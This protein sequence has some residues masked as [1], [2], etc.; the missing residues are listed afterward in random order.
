MTD[1]FESISKDE[2]LIDI[3]A[4]ERPSND[5][6]Y[7]KKV[8]NE[9]NEN[10][11]SK[12]QP[13]EEKSES[14]KNSHLNE[15][16]LESESKSREEIRDIEI[17]IDNRENKDENHDIEIQIDN[18]KKQEEMLDIGKLDNKKKELIN[19]VKEEKNIDIKKPIQNLIPSFMTSTFT[20]SVT[21]KKSPINIK[22]QKIKDKNLTEED[23]K[24][25]ELSTTENIENEKSVETSENTPENKNDMKIEIDDNQNKKENEKLMNNNEFNLNTNKEDIIGKEK[26]DCMLKH[27]DNINDND[28][29]LI[30]NEDNKYY[31]NKNIVKDT[32]DIKFEEKE[33]SEQIKEKDKMQEIPGQLTDKEKKEEN[34]ENEINNENEKDIGDKKLEKEN[35]FLGRKREEPLEQDNQS[36]TASKKQEMQEL[37]LLELV[38]TYSY[39]YIFNIILKNCLIYDDENENENDSDVNAIVRNL[40]REAS[41][42]RVMSIIL[43]IGSLL[44]E[45]IMFVNKNTNN[46]EL[47]NLKEEEQNDN[48][49]D[50][51]IN[52]EYINEDNNNDS[53][54]NKENQNEIQILSQPENEKEIPEQEQDF[55]INR[56]GDIVLYEN[57][58]EKRK[59]LEKQKE[60]EIEMK[61]EREKMKEEINSGKLGEEMRIIHL[62]K[63]N[64]N[65]IQNKLFTIEQ[66]KELEEAI[67]IEQNKYQNKYQNNMIIPNNNI[68]FNPNTNLFSVT[69]VNKGRRK[70]RFEVKKPKKKYEDDE[71]YNVYEDLM[72]QRRGG[73]ITDDRFVVVD[74]EGRLNKDLSEGEESEEEEDDYPYKKRYRQTPLP[75]RKQER[76]RNNPLK[77]AP[78]YKNLFTITNCQEQL[79]KQLIQILNSSIRHKHHDE[80]ADYL[81]ESLRNKKF[82]KQGFRIETRGRKKKGAK[83]EQKTEPGNGWNNFS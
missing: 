32:K 47:L 73:K 82:D 81:N 53:N 8:E 18:R 48:D 83:I 24:N 79:K 39:G 45:Q 58:E 28:I 37:K 69:P 9:L 46:N 75:P 65:T 5:Y 57:S 20:F 66:K 16:N 17:Q 55:T 23:K 59:E 36:E 34:K 35:E 51:L 62:D 68:N 80:L 40:I 31:K 29:I 38:Q 12:K 27:N 33:I 11:I 1:F 71:N 25:I 30:D 63:V 64:E 78:T 19:E 2:H 14:E 15:K 3:L 6:N 41:Y 42:Q 43:A 60:R 54:S 21:D 77:L 44:G 22:S 67:Q 13:L 52:T 49:N 72:N 7:Q 4:D 74:D 26:I 76:M 56:R 70:V 50:N 10:I 61:K